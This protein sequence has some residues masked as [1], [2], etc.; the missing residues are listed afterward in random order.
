MATG[1]EFVEN[2]SR[3]SLRVLGAV[4]EPINPEAQQCFYLKVGNKKSPIV[5][6][7]WQTEAGCIL[8]TPLQV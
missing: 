8:I 1:N 2:T 5:D 6:T 7:W 3:S 4:G